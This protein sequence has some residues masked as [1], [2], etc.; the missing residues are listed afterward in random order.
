MYGWMVI[1]LGIHVGNLLHFSPII[2]WEFHRFSAD[3]DEVTDRLPDRLTE[4]SDHV[5]MEGIFPGNWT[6]GKL[7]TVLL[8]GIFT[9]NLGYSWMDGSGDRDGQSSRWNHI[10][11]DR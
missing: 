4:E 9:M 7:C 5:W 6:F 8:M 3:G 1:L 11:V 10:W 2:T